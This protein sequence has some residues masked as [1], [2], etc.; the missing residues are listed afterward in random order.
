MESLTATTIA[1]IVDDLGTVLAQNRLGV[2][3]FGRLTDQTDHADNMV[4]R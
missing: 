2:E 4:W 1:M 3:V